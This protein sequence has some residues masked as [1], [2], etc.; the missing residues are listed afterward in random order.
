MDSDKLY[1]FTSKMQW[2]FQQLAYLLDNAM[3]KW[4]INPFPHSEL[5]VRR[6]IERIHFWIRWHVRAQLA[7]YA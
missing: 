1:Y 5:R 2:I 3:E 7:S 4:L 6:N